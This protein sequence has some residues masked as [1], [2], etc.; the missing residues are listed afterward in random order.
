ME[1]NQT[2]TFVTV[3]RDNS[4]RYIYIYILIH[5]YIDILLTEL[6]KRRKCQRKCVNELLQK[7]L[8]YHCTESVGLILL[9]VV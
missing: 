9:E 8:R 4:T 2:T 3:K 6:K 7:C 1:L 5:T